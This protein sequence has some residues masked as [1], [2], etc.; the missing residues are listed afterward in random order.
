MCGRFTLFLSIA[1]ITD[2]F[3]VY[4]VDW[5]QEPSYNIAPGQNIAGV[6][7]KD[8][9]KSLTTL[10]WGLIPHWAKEENIGYR[11]INA[12]AETLTQKPTFS[13]PFKTQR[14]I[15]PANGFYEWKQDIVSRKKTP[16]YI[17][18]SSGKP[19]GFAGLYDT[20][21]SKEGNIITSCTI[22]TTKPNALIGQLHNRMPVILEPNSREMW[23]D[24]TI[25]EPQELIPL[26]KP[27]DADEMAMY[28]VS[29][30]VN[31]IKYNGPDCIKPVEH[32]DPH[33]NLKLF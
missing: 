7:K 30:M 21:K 19:M 14:C 24:K 28:E 13:R 1:E 27:Y 29:K 2:E 18:L 10:R 3:E 15:I 8:G 6:L 16:F 31:S 20:W 9:D 4:D 5:I 26:L 25:Q 12:R 22:I 32:I 33:E 23:L 17:K 11:M